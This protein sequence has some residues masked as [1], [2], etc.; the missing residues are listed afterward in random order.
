M[1]RW[2]ALGALLAVAFWQSEVRLAA[3]MV[4]AEFDPTTIERAICYLEYSY[5]EA[6]IIW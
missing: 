2:L 4:V 6:G 1:W 5:R 3:C